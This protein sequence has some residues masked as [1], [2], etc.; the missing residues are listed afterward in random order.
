MVSTLHVII[1]SLC[2]LSIF[3]LSYA[4]TQPAFAAA[5]QNRTDS[6]TEN[7]TKDLKSKINNLIS[8]AL[9]DTDNTS[10]ALSDGSNLSSSQI[11]ISKNKVVSTTSSNDSY[12]DTS[13]KNKITTVNGVCNSFKVG[14]NGDDS[15]SSSGN[16]NDE[17]TG[18]KGADKF[19]CGEGEDT[20]KDY[21]PKE[22]D[23]IL[24]RE[25]CEKI[26]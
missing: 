4:N 10:F 21:N 20:I 19:T 1:S 15:L 6:V 11:V 26:L 18:G 25:N 23:I 8:D 5:E 24:D 3:F 7:F 2:L 22:G 9:N 16:C 13:I 14:G 12:G 17:L